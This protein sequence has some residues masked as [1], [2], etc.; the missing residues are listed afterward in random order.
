MARFVK[1]LDQEKRLRSKAYLEERLRALTEFRDLQFIHGINPINKNLLLDYLKFLAFTDVSLK[2]AANTKGN[3]KL[4]FTWNKEYNGDRNFKQLTQKQATEFFKWMKEQG[5]TC[6]RANIVKTDICDFADYLQYVVG[7]EQY[8]HDGTS[9]RWYNYN[10]QFWKKVNVEQEEDASIIKKPNCLDFDRERLDTLHVYLKR[11]QDWMGV[12]I[13]EYAHLGSD[14]LQLKIDD[15]EFNRQP[16][17]VQSYFKWR[18]RENV[19]EDLK[20]VCVMRNHK[21]GEIMPMDIPTLRGYTKMFS[22][23]LGKEFVIC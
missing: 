4:F 9:N 10:G 8:K 11:K 1:S 2:T 5:Y 21:T 13:L 18:S 3:L 17:Y 7:R 15:E 12:V 23:F 14:I 22:I 19:P 20:D 16:G 6:I